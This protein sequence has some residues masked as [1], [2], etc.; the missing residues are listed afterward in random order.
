[1]LKYL[2]APL[3][4][5]GLSS[6]GG[7]SSS[8]DFDAFFPWNPDMEGLETTES[9]IQY[10]VVKEGPED[11][12]SPTLENTVQV[13]YDGRLTDGTPFDGNF[14]T[15]R[16]AMFGV[17]QVIPGWTQGLQ[18]M[19]EGDEYIFFI[20]SELGYGQTPRPGSVIKPGD[21]LV[22]RVELMKVFQP[23]PA[24]EAAWNEYTPW[25]SAREGV[26]STESGL[27]YV[28][29]ESGSADGKTPQP[30]DTVVVLYEGRFAETGEV[31]DSAYQRGAP[32]QFQANG[33][34]PGWQE[35]LSMMRPGDRWLLH[36]PSDL[37]YGARGHPAGIAPN[38][39]LNFEVELIDVLTTE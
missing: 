16:P 27:E 17:T 24:D 39:D 35:A 13:F 26:Q 14:G 36:I 20:P 10:Y 38:T 8:T 5:L 11:G 37:A 6:C 18:L 19:S 15:G 30:S 9:G 28:V 7:P 4:A 34:I 25:D 33:V 1:M 23:K 3:L 31:F 21:D 29:L 32:A 22:F 12:A 2:A